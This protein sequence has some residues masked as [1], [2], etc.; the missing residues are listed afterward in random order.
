MANTFFVVLPSNVSDYPDNRPN[1]YRVHLPKPIEF[2]GGN[3]VCGLYSIQY[4]QSW[5]ATIGTDAKQWIDI[6]YRNQKPRRVGIPKTT[7]L[8]PGG[9]RYFLKLVLSD[10]AKSRKRREVLHERY[11]DEIIISPEISLEGSPV[12]KRQ[13]RDTVRK[14][15]W[16]EAFFDQNPHN[17]WEAIRD[18]EHEFEQHNA[19]VEEKSKEVRDAE[20]DTQKHVLQQELDHLHSLSED[21][22]KEIGLLRDEAKTRDDRNDQQIAREFLEKHQDD[23]HEQIIQMEINIIE[24][25]IELEEKIRES[26][27]EEENARSSQEIQRF[28]NSI[29]RMRKNLEALESAVI[30]RDLKTTREEFHKQNSRNHSEYVQSFFN[31]HPEDHW[32]TLKKNLRDLKSLHVQIREKRE[33]HLQESDEGKKNQLGSEIDQLNKLALYRRNR[34]KAIHLEAVKKWK[35]FG[36]PIPP[37]NEEIKDMQKIEE[38]R[39]PEYLENVGNVDDQGSPV[40]V[41]PPEITE[42]MIDVVRERHD[43]EQEKE[44]KEREQRDKKEQ[45]KHAR[46]IELESETEEKEE[47]G[48]SRRKPELDLEPTPE[49]IP[50]EEIYEE[51]EEQTDNI[52]E[53][54][55]AQGQDLHSVIEFD[56]LDSIDRFRA[57]FNDPEIREIVISPQLGY[58]LGF[59]AGPV[60]NGQIGKYG[61]DLKGGFTS[62]AFTQKDLQ[63]V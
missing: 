49:I 59:P 14:P 29:K 57:V 40:T 23:Y 3:W 45:L 48:K 56:Y 38:R 41:P 11:E 44:R 13:R 17:Y 32:V 16:L 62:F 10:K 51:Y 39:H 20:D 34:F 63:V 12:K 25:Y 47:G 19:K 24:R 8:T 53:E 37:T 30:E 26:K 33:A 54:K 58:V 36:I 5:A 9:L 35:S 18:F 46:R 50:T 4:P 1:K 2:Q 60:V 27:D 61:I 28:I 6:H 43:F 52:I 7:Q 22:K 21:K 15:L 55:E 31:D 42:E